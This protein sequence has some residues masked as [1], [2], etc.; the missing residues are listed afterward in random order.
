[1]GAIV[2]LTTVAS[3][4][5]ASRLARGLVE[6]RHAACVNIVPIRRSVYR[7]RGEICDEPE[8]LLVIKSRSEEYEA[9]AAAIRE[10]HSYEQPEILALEVARG[11]AGY[12]AW[13]ADC[14]AKE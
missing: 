14:L 4:E 7:W 6:L 5:Q 8:L 3:E 13:L 12:L 9:L 1:M 2:V 11:D 10:L